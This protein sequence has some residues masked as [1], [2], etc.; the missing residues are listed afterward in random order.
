MDAEDT[1]V[2]ARWTVGAGIILAALLGVAL[3][4]LIGR[5]ISTPLKRAGDVLD[6]VAEGDST[7][8]LE[9]NSR[10]EVGVLSHRLNR[11]VASG[12]RVMLEIY[13]F[14]IAL[15]TAAKE[16]K[17]LIHDSRRKVDEGAAHVRASGETV[18]E[19]VG[20]VKRVTAMVTEISAA[21]REQNAGVDQVSKALSQVDQVTQSNAAKT[22]ELSSTA[23]SLA[24]DAEH[25]RALVGRFKLGAIATD[26]SKPVVCRAVGAGAT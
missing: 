8:S 12:R 4:F 7:K 6:L 19:I 5:C 17:G 21:S 13:E 18:A 3:S 24:S 22:E 23:Q 14:S 25:L 9:I 10:Y 16:I 15:A 1:N 11:T 20:S 26:E 2:Q